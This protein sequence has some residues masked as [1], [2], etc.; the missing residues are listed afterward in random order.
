MIWLLAEPLASNA[1]QELR[2]GVAAVD[3]LLVLGVAAAFFYSVVSVVRGHGHVYFEIA[4]VV[5]VLVTLGRLVRSG[6]K[7]ARHASDRNAEHA[8][9]AQGAT[10]RRQ[11]RTY[12][13]VGRPARG[14]LHPRSAWRTDRR[15][16]L[17]R[18]RRRG[19]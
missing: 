16:R 2:R 12:D 19:H 18:N 9:A 10:D 4:C 8:V 3:L 7:A 11:R 5:L 1:W 14:R 13:A 17:H 15:R 6:G